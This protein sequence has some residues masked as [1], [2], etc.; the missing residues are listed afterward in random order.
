MARRNK[1]RAIHRRFVYGRFKLTTTVGKNSTQIRNW[2]GVGG[3]SRK[4]AAAKGTLVV[5]FS[6]QHSRGEPHSLTFAVGRKILVVDLKSTQYIPENLKSMLK[7]SLVVG[8]G[9]SDNLEIIKSLRS[10]VYCPFVEDLGLKLNSV[11]PG[12][13]RSAAL[14]RTRRGNVSVE[15]ARVAA[16]EAFACSLKAKEWLGMPMPI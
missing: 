10:R 3:K 12:L 15:G 16:L 13:N 1:E 9:M 6:I 5:G 7:K 14:G 4:A 2:V 8:C 11:V